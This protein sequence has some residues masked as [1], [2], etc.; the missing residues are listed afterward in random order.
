MP[1]WELLLTVGLPRSGKTTWALKS[2]YP[3]V[4]RDAIRLALHGH[5]YLQAAEDMVTAIETYMVGALFYAGHNSVI[6]DAC[7]MK[8]KYRD[9]WKWDEWKIKTII[10]DT[11]ADICIQRA[12]ATD[13]GDLV[14]VIERMAKHAEWPNDID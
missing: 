6:V 1:D 4:N 2:P 11:P 10:F 3:V 5:A 8:K 14:S 7:H 9:R 12:R 13:R